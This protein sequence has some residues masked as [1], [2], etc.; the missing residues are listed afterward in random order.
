MRKAK[1]TSTLQRLRPVQLAIRHFSG[2]PSNVGIVAIDTYFP[3]KYVSQK[4]LEKYDGV[5]EGKY[6]VGLGQNNMAFCDEREDIN[7]IAASAVQGLLEK[8]RI[9]PKDIGHLQVGTE[10]IVDKSKSVKTF[11]MPIFADHGNTSIEGI[12]TTNACYGG[13]A[14]VFNALQWI[15]SSYW[16]G[17]YAVVVAADIA[18]YEK[19]PARPTGGVGAVAMLIGPNAPLVFHSG[20]RSTY[21]EHAYDFYKPVL[22]SEYPLVD[23]ALSNECYIRALDK[24]FENFATKY[25]TLRGKPFDLNAAYDYAVFHSP[26]SKLVQK[27]WAR[28]HFLNYLR[29]RQS[30]NPTQSA[31][32]LES[33]VGK[34]LSQTY[35]DKNLSKIT[36]EESKAS[37]KAKVL[38]SLLLGQELGNSYCG[39]LYAGVHSL[40]ETQRSKLINKN[41]LLFS[42]G[43][44]LASSLFSLEV[45]KDPSYIAENTKITKRLQERIKADPTEFEDCLI[46]REKYHAA[47]AVTL[48]YPANPSAEFFPGTYFLKSINQSYHR[49]YERSQL[50]QH[51]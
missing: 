9:N 15:E 47:S 5:G 20:L 26:Y 44:G 16:D 22:T 35:D 28:L 14:A 50:V 45:V 31:S 8:F 12:D 25:E 43:S 23:G 2:R 24:C 34:D 46:R 27:S 13:T 17:R 3:R 37:Y 36:I 11:L 21:M 51:N 42:Y 38:P 49:L 39:S 18:V 32:P 29:T 6:T 33:Y 4:D 1:Y 30:A 41:V 10:T 48:P 19:G 40:V 7:S